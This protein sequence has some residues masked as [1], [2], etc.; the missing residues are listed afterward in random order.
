MKE[1]VLDTETTGISV[2]DGHRIVE[3][4]CIEL[5]NLIPTKNNFHYYLNPERKVS[6]KAFEVHGYT[7]EF[8]SKQ[9]KFK[10]I[11]HGFFNRSGGRSSGIYKSLNCG[12]GSLDKKNN[13]LKNLEI[14]SK[15]IGCSKKKLVLLHQVHSNKFNFIDKGRVFQKG[16]DRE[17]RYLAK[18]AIK[19]I[20]TVEAL[21]GKAL[22]P[23]AEADIRKAYGK[24]ANSII[25][26]IQVG[27]NYNYPNLDKSMLRA[28]G[29]ID[30]DNLTRVFGNNLFEA[31]NKLPKN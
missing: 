30:T 8:L 31:I 9:K 10:E 27:I 28:V 2:K 26:Q 18:N 11:K 1:V 15:K 19:E 13:V 16:G 4:G 3:I 20:A 25:R 14:V 12:I 17:L 22:T 29:R 6:E 23:A 5:D 24:R 7:D 21:S